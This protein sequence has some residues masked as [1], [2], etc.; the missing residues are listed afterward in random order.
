[1][2]RQNTIIKPHFEDAL[3]KISQKEVS[4][5]QIQKWI[6]MQNDFVQI[7]IKYKITFRLKMDT[8]TK[9]KEFHFQLK[10]SNVM[11]RH[12]RLRARMMLQKISWSKYTSLYTIWKRLLI[13]K[14]QIN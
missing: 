14:T 10:L 1:M 4:L 5:V 6:P 7:L 12:Q 3:K 2:T 11:R 9:M 13:S 8:I